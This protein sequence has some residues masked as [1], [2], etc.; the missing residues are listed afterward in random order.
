[1]ENQRGLFVGL[2]TLDYL[3]QADHPPAANEK[4]VAVQS[5]IAAG[6]P[7]TNAAVAFS[8]LGNTVEVMGVLGQHPLAK[9]VWQ[10]LQ[11]Q[12]VGI[13]DLQA[14]RRDAPPVSSIVVTAATGERAVISSNATD[15]QAQSEAIPSPSL[16]AADIVL[17]DGHQMSVSRAIAAQA[18]AQNIPVIIDAGSWKP[19]FE[20]VLPFAEVV[21][22]SANFQPPGCHSADDTFS[23]LRQM[24]I[25]LI[26]MTFGS[27]PIQYQTTTEAGQLEVPAIYPVDTLGAGDIFHGAF[28]HFHP[29]LPFPAALAEASKIAAFSCQYWGTRAWIESYRQRRG[30]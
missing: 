8:Q 12:G 9:L 20:A 23:Y 3:Y 18:K 22:A 17:I 24:D 10:D 30:G 26:A 21:I 11:A 15:R 6:G 14:H 7:V 25:S 1:M 29:H 27:E 28:C 4:V 16:D 13:I 19:G 2:I 5:L